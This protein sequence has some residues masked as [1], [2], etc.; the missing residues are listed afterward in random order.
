M[1]LMRAAGARLPTEDPEEFARRVRAPRSCRS[2]GDFL[3]VFDVFMPFLK[4]PEALERLAYELCEDC[5]AQHVARFEA[6]VA[7][8]LLVKDGFGQED[9]VRA[10]P[11]GLERGRKDFP[12]GGALLLCC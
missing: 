3:K 2:L 1:E 12:V 6:R 7:P 5:A 8:A 9:A 10:V 11:R 4:S